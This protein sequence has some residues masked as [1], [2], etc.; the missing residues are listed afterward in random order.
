MTANKMSL[1]GRFR[2]IEIVL[3]VLGCADSLRLCGFSLVEVRGP[4]PG[5]VLGLLFAVAALV[6]EHRL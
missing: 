4:L 1:L 3:C 2:Q 5:W 6:A